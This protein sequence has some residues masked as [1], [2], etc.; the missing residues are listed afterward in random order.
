ME[1]KYQF[2]GPKSWI[3]GWDGNN[4]STFTANI[5]ANCASTFKLSVDAEKKDVYI[6]LS[7]ILSM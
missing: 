3:V 1:T 5:V 4:C 2:K 6:S 7:Q